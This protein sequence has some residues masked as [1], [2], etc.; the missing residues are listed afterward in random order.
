MK[1]GT[2]LALKEDGPHLLERIIAQ[3][4]EGY[5]AM[6]HY[7]EVLLSTAIGFEGLVAQ[8]KAL[9]KLGRKAEAVGWMREYAP[10]CEAAIKGR[11]PVL[12]AHVHDLWA[13]IHLQGEDNQ[14]LSIC[15]EIGTKQSGFP[16]RPSRLRRLQGDQ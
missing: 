8:T 6:L 10:R 7:S 14:Q 13:R 2:L 15:G 5:P 1:L 12:V 11:M 3:L 9:V 4:G 16:A